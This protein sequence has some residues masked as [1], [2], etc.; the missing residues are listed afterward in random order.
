MPERLAVLTLAA[1]ILGGGLHPQPGLSSRH[2]AANEIICQRRR[3]MGDE[4]QRPERAAR[5]FND[6]APPSASVEEV[7]L[8]LEPEDRS[9]PL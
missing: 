5:W 6:G 2:Q 7:E 9:R 4:H 3:L 1:L 8:S